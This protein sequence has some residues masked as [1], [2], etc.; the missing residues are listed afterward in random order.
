MALAQPKQS[1][2]EAYTEPN[3][4]ATDAVSTS[5]CSSTLRSARI[6]LED[7]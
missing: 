6:N 4:E 5:T 2:T 7:R 3:H 1:A